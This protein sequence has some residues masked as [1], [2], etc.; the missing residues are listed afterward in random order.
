MAKRLPLPDQE[1]ILDNSWLNLDEKVLTSELDNPFKKKDVKDIEHPHHQLLRIM[2]NPKYFGFTCKYLFNRQLHPFQLAILRELWIRPFPMLIAS[3][4]AGKSFMLALYAMLRATLTQG[5]KVAVVGAAFRQAKVVFDYCEEI[6]RTAPILRDMCG[7]EKRQGPKRD[8]DRCTLRI[9]DSLIFAL[10]LGDGSKIRGQRANYII[11]DEF[12][13]VPVDIYETVVAGFAVVSSDPIEKVK[14]IAKTKAMK[15]LGLITEEQEREQK[16]RLLSNQ[17]IISGTAYYGFNH[18][19]DYW[20]RWKKIIESKGDTKKLQE[21]FGGEIDENFNWKDYSVIRIPY[22]LLP[23]GFMDSKH[24]A[25][26]RA[27]VH[28]ANFMMEFGAVFPVD[29]DGFFKRSLIES[30]VVG[31]PQHPIEVNGRF[32]EFSA[33][34]RGISN[35]KYI[36]AIDP[37]SEH[38]NFSVVVLEVWPEHR[39]VVYCWTTTKAKFRDKL[40]HGTVKEKDFFSYAVRKI[41][42]VLSLFKPCEFIAMDSQGGGHLIAEGLHDPDKMEEFEQPIWPVVDPEDPQPTDSKVG[43]HILKLINFSDAKWVSEANHGMRKD[44]EDRVLLFPCIDSAALGMAMEEDAY[45]GRKAGGYELLEDCMFEIEELKD[46]L[47]TIVHT[48]TGTTLRDHWSTPEVKMAGGKKGR[49]RKDR[50]S[51]L[52]MANMVARTSQRTHQPA[53][54]GIMGGSVYDLAKNVPVASSVQHQNPVWYQQAIE[55]YRDFGQVITRKK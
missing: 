28:K 15:K 37:A 41:R 6:W 54:A 30:C 8:V 25:K 40:K 48:Q 11:A 38:D 32:V 26:S 51:S 18:F 35:R 5:C 34:L 19:C 47:A 46:E 49:M 1:A 24:I 17:A 3:R 33:M 53:Y 52:L 44:F 42:D 2:M 36:I 39:R 4:G 43:L 55:S 14:N 21:I 13:S 31:N 9:G 29:S 10:P 16:N 7:K 22:Q 50:Y 23:E 45:S 27:T 12:A 20:K